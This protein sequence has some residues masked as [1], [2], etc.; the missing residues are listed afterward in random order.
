MQELLHQLFTLTTF[1]YIFITATF[2][3]FLWGVVSVPLYVSVHA[4]EPKNFKYYAKMLTP[5]IVAIAMAIYSSFDI[6][7]SWNSVTSNNSSYT[8]TR[9]N[10]ILHVVSNN[11]NLKNEDVD[12]VIENN[13]YLY[14]KYNKKIIE[15]K[16][17]E[18]KLSN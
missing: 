11:K 16:K 5:L 9:E 10:K 7:G 2:A 4:F 17:D 6:Q 14:V 12:I 15:I 13:E 18:L 1:Q 8:I 3:I